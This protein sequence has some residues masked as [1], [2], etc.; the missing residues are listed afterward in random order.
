MKPDTKFVTTFAVQVIASLVLAS[1]AEGQASGQPPP[2]KT[3][4]YQGDTTWITRDSGTTRMI[5]KADTLITHVDQAGTSSGATWLLGPDSAR[6]LS[7]YGVPPFRM[8]MRTPLVMMEWQSAYW[9]RLLTTG[10]AGPTYAYNRVSASGRVSADTLWLD[11]S[12]GDTYRSVRRGDTL[13]IMRRSGQRTTD[14]TW[15]IRGDSAHMTD[16]SGKILVSVPKIVILALDSAGRTMATAIEI[17]FHP[18]PLEEEAR[19]NRDVH[20]SP[21][22]HPSAESA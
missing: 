5:L 16:R 1:G 21:A 20:T 15:V 22:H 17:P 2:A 7:H 12:N 13:A 14:E 11:Y 18:R 9:S 4:R 8:S 3:Y 10:V 6:V 19:G